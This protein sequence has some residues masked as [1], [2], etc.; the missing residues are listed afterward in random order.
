MSVYETI[1]VVPL[2]GALGAE[3]RGLDLSRPMTTNVAGELRR[4]WLD[5]Q[6]IFLRGQE[7]T[8]EQHIAF[9]KQWGEIHHHPF[10][11]PLD[12][13]PEILDI[14]KTEDMT[15]NNGG[16][17]HSDQ[18]YTVKPA[19]ATILFAREIPEAG[20]DTMFSNAYLAYE[21]LS[22]GL[23]S[24]LGSLQAVNNG[25]S[26]RHPS[27]MTRGERAAAGIGTMPQKAPGDV[28][29][30]SVHPVVRTHPETGRKA[31]YIGGHTE[32]FEGMTEEESRPLIDY[33]LDLATRP[34]FT[35]RLRWEAGTL[36][37]WDNRCTQHFAIN[38]YDGQ[39]RR[40]HK[41]TV[42]GDT[43]Y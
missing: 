18:M 42:A 32:R 35:C 1:E 8:P 21:A 30:I 38:D 16:R 5:H 27:G 24:T 31:L 29:T 9:A 6:V 3:I 14:L 15:R 17:W 13:Y 2:S 4:A 20:G 33:L 28:Q 25:D 26:R 43:P 34:E 12:N 22:G 39:R 40:V 19:K 37:M 41:I 36:T 11:K 10:N 23:R 7:L